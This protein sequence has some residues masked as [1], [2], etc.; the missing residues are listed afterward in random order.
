[1][2]D[3]VICMCRQSDTSTARVVWLGPRGAAGHLIFNGKG[4]S[5]LAG[6]ELMHRRRAN[7]PVGLDFHKE[8]ILVAVARSGRS[9]SVDLLWE[10]TNHADG[11]SKLCDRLGRSASG[12]CFA[13]RPARA[14]MEASANCHP[15]APALIPSEDK[16]SRRHDNRPPLS[17]RRVAAV[18]VPDTD[19][20]ACAN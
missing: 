2:A 19:H 7:G 4:V 11:I 18:L 3:W 14:A 16:P 1:M 12:W 9:D 15:V 5:R 6:A 17:S 8:R 10:I 13:M 20:E